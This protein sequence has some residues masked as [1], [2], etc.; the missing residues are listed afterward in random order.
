MARCSEPIRNDFLEFIGSHSGVAR[1][2]QLRQALLAG[3]GERPHIV[4]K[5]C[6]ERL[7]VF[8]FGMQGCQ[9]LHT[10]ECKS[11]L[12]GPRLLHP[13]GAIIVECSDALG[14]RHKIR[15]AL[16]RRSGHEIQ[17]CLLCRAVIP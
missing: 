10:I 4:F 15:R 5:D 6:L 2:D 1:H 12:S 11:Q 7:R 13:Q 14:G 3:F 9:S 8:P 17:D 16:S